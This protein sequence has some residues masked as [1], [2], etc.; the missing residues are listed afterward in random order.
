MSSHKTLEQKVT[1]ILNPAAAG[2]RTGR[3]VAELSSVLCEFFGDPPPIQLTD[4]PLSATSL[5][6]KA[7]DEGSGL[8]VAVG[9]DGTIHEVIN[10]F[11]HNGHASGMR[12]ELAIISSGTGCG[13]AQSI[14]LPPNVREQIKLSVR[15]MGRRVDL[16][17]V[18][19]YDFEGRESHRY[20]VNE[21]Q[22]GIGGA[23]VKCVQSNH[24]K[25]GGSMAFALGTL[26]TVFQHRNQRITIQCDGGELLT[27]DLTGVVIANGAFTGGGMN[28][29]PN[30]S[31]S[32][33]FL[34]VLA[35]DHLSVFDRLRVFPRIY[36]G[37][38]VHLPL[39]S[40]RLATTISI[41]SHESVLVEADGELLGTTPCSVEI[42]PSA[43]RVRMPVEWS[44]S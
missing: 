7:I 26:E 17:R 28:L 15:G 23:V 43:I 13:F 39:F 6:R 30:A 35:M 42:I 14:G 11:Y 5:T 3:R 40:Y 20:F 2:G 44:A 1:I 25:L 18:T 16:G 8:I 9:G 29:A 37:T 22:L 41:T 36:A 10:G 21:C 4:G 33:G 31:V 32:D 24:K 12:P 38:H 19:F 34:N 27:K